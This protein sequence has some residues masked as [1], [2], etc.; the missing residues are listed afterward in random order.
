MSRR[1]NAVVAG[2]LTVGAVAA[3]VTVFNLPPAESNDGTTTG[4]PTETAE[5]AKKTL[6]DSE[7]HDGTLGHGDTSSIAAGRQGTV[8]ALAASGSTV[9]RGKP[10]YKIDNKPVSLLYGALPAYRTLRVGVEGSDVLQFEKNLWALGYRGFTVDDEYTS[11]TADAV[12]EWQDDLGRDETGTVE[13]DQIHYASGQVRVDSH[14]AERGAVVQPGTE[15]LKTTGT[16]MLATVTLDVDA[17]RLARKGATVDVTLPDGSEV[18][19]K[20]TGVETVV[21][22]GQGNEEDTT[23]IEVT[24]AFAESPQGLDEA[25]VTVDFVSSQRENVLTVPVAALL[26]LSEG[27]YGVE[28]AENGGTRVVAVKTGLFA[29]GEVEV[30]GGG[31][32]AGTRVVVP[33]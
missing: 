11:A 17:Q 25:A 9:T 7:S 10:L 33:S 28:V 19:G 6:V 12:E 14:S 5:V 22:T 3:A 30:S 20:I 24:V 1:G 29:G 32:Q 15:V 8:T 31:L 4:K 23:K 27:G 18:N 26:A 2:V 16:T 13:T 21:E